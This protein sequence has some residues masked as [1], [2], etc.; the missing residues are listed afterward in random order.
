M[1]DVRIGRAAATGR[2]LANPMLDRLLRKAKGD[3]LMAA[4][5]VRSTLDV[6]LSHGAWPTSLAQYLQHWVTEMSEA[7]A[8]IDMLVMVDTE[9]TSLQFDRFLEEED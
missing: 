1:I 4:K 9:L 2:T 5:A 8:S 3:W 6:R 7:E